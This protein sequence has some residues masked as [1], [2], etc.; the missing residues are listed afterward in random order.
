[1][2]S[3]TNQ[4]DIKISKLSDSGK[5]NYINISSYVLFYMVEIVNLY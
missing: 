1:M 2:F 5:L 3:Y 4:I